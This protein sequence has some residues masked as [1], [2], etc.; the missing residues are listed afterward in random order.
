MTLTCVTAWAAEAEAEPTSGL[1]NLQ[2]ESAYSGFVQLTAMDASGQIA[3]ASSEDRDIFPGAVKVGVTCMNVQS[4]KEYLLIVQSGDNATPNADDMVYIDQKSP[5]SGGTVTNMFTIYP[6]KPA[7]TANS[8]TYSVYMSSNAEASTGITKYEKVGSFEYY[9][10]GLNVLLG[11][12]D[13]DGEIMV[14]DAVMVLRAVV[15]DIVLDEKQIAAADVDKDGSVMV[16]DAVYILRYVVE[17]ITS[18]DNLNA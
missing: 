7:I 2:V 1:R 17:D 3:K 18:F 8:V 5:A 9:S 4:G 14:A 15:E 10:T 16:S 13:N 12:V 11:D 6:K